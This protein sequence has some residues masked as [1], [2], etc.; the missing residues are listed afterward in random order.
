MKISDLAA[1]TIGTGLYDE[2]VQLNLIELL[3]ASPSPAHWKLADALEAAA[4]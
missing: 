2:I 1:A 4:A 3:R